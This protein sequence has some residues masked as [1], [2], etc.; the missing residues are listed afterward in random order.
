MNEKITVL[1]ADDNKEFT[2]TL[3]SYLENEEEFQI[4]GI[5]KDGNEAYE[6]AVQLKPDILLLDVIMPHLDGLGVLEKLYNTQLEKMPLSIILSA[7]GQ[8]KITQKAI[9]LGTQ[10]YIVKP[11]DLEELLA[12]IETVLRR[13]NKVSSVLTAGK[14][15][16]DIKTRI[17]TLRGEEVFLSAKEFDLL[18]YLIRNKNIALW[19]ERI[20][21]EVWKEPYYGGTRTVD[22][23]IGRLRKKLDMGDAIENIYKVGYKF[24]PEKLK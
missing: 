4:I 2:M 16:V 3:S 22:L 12:R 13:Y 1:I 9:S 24:L 11:F 10:Y 20:Y 7:V 17:V 19:R 21:E 23:H 15:S 14:I 18:L 5:A 6:L 8:D